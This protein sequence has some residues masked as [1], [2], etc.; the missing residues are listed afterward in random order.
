M[1]NKT[2][3]ATI[4]GATAVGLIK[5]QIGSSVK[6][7]TVPYILVVPG[8][9][10]EWIIRNIP[11]HVII[12]QPMN[13]SLDDKIKRVFENNTPKI[14]DEYKHLINKITYAYH[15][16]LTQ[17][18]D[19]FYSYHITASPRIHFKLNIFTDWLTSVHTRRKLNEMF[20]PNRLDFI[21]F[22]IRTNETFFDDALQREFGYMIDS[23][24]EYYQ[25]FPNEYDD[26]DYLWEDE[27][28]VN[29]FENWGD[30][31]ISVYDECAIIDADTGKIYNPT[32]KIS[33]NIRVR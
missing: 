30:G 26:S 15:D 25:Q 3:I 2:S 4:L 24:E 23:T 12:N 13:G 9:G 10:L 18:W 7:T 31:A 27:D 19:G 14:P 21:D 5:K 20:N 28:W 32:K 1:L 22:L 29:R 16:E 17:R 11:E 8:Q 6:L 33:T